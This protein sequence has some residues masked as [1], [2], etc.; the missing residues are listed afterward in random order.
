MKN[1]TPSIPFCRIL[2][3]RIQRNS[4]DDDDVTM[5]PGYKYF[6]DH[7][8][9][10][11]NSYVLDIPEDG[12]FVKYETESSTPESPPICTTDDA[13]N[14]SNEEVNVCL[15]TDMQSAITKLSAAKTPNLASD[16]QKYRGKTPKSAEL[17]DAKNGNIKSSDVCSKA[18]K[19]E[20]NYT[21]KRRSKR[22]KKH[23]M[24]LE[25]EDSDDAAEILKVEYCGQEDNEANAKELFKEKLMEELKVPYCEDEH[26]KLLQ[27]ISVRKPVQHHKDL[28]GR[29][30]I[31]DEDYPGF[32]FLDHH[33][34]LAEKIDSVHDD[35]PRVLNLLR[36]FFYWLK[37]LS[38]EGAFMPWRDPSCLDVLPQQ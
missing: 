4:N 34:D 16:S 24:K 21:V 35:H 11:G 3:S 20:G 10:H 26:K 2:L 30:K 23:A 25:I 22:L 13:H 29:I 9:P 7:L 18:Q 33:V 15:D 5:D 17:S 36:G 31:Y 8:R 28:R 1:S 38:H 32:S 37:N 27:D 12:V 14:A 19:H 6:L